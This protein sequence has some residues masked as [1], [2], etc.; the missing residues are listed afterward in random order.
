MKTSTRMVFKLLLRRFQVDCVCDIGACDGSDSL[1]FREALPQAELMAFE[2]N[3]IMYN[4]MTGDPT[5]REARIRLLP[6][7]ITNTNG[8]AQF[9]VAESNYEDENATHP[10]LSS[11]LELGNIKQKEVVTV[12]TRRIDEFIL[13]EY[14]KVQ[15]IALWI[16]AEGAEFGIIEGIA[17]IKDRVLALHVE[18]A[19]VPLRPGQRLYSEVE[20]LM[21]SFGF[22]PL[23]MT[24]SDDLRWADVVFVKEKLL[25]ELDFGFRFRQSVGA[26]AN[27]CKLDSAGVLLKKYCHPLYVPLR[28]VYFRLFN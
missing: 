10:G 12:Q 7:A 22:V 25:A 18:T 8:T 4:K 14:P 21:K 13:S 20:P 3:P 27:A 26:L 17:G 9:H 5:F 24:K 1:I 2:A 19:F 11:L 28:R 15:K 23:C 16:D 6:Y